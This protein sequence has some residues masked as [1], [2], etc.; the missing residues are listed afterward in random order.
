MV[1]CK[2]NE[3]LYKSQCYFFLENYTLL[4]DFK[5]CE[6]PSGTI[7]NGAH[8]TSVKIK[9]RTEL[10]TEIN[11]SDRL[12][13]FYPFWFHP[14]YFRICTLTVA[15]ASAGSITY[16]FRVTNKFTRN[17]SKLCL[18]LLQNMRLHHIV[19]WTHWTIVDVKKW[20]TSSARLNPL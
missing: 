1:K 7:T 20:K 9:R 4:N 12:I 18:F 14:F 8:S 6:I 19:N 16:A 2:C 13:A 15:K 5:I 3:Q 10:T 11:Q 17:T